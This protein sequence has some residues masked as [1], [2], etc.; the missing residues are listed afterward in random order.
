MLCDNSSVHYNL[1]KQISIK[2]FVV[3]VQLVAKAFPPAP[4]IIQVIKTAKAY[5]KEHPKNYIGIH[6][7]Y[8][9]L[10]CPSAM[11]STLSNR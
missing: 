9:A 7:A 1:Y 3:I 5:W 4:A 8:G 11:L 2:S 6:C 10:R